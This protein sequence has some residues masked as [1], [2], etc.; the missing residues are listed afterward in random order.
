MKLT[1][2]T[3]GDKRELSRVWVSTIPRSRYQA[4]GVPILQFFFNF[5]QACTA[6]C[7]PGLF[8]VSSFAMR[9][10]SLFIISSCGCLWVVEGKLRTN[11]EIALPYSPRSDN[12]YGLGICTSV[13]SCRR[14]DGSIGYFDNSIAMIVAAIQSSLA[15]S[16]IADRRAM[17]CRNPNRQSLSCEAGDMRFRTSQVAVP[18]QSR[19]FQHVG[20]FASLNM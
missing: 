15:S 10:L 3:G 8:D 2:R 4:W 18:C 9:Q 14:E 13:L 12:G 20:I 5:H 7:Q 6:D 11:G 19:T 16:Q 17:W 1:L